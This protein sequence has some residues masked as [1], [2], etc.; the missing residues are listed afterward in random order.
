MTPSSQS[1]LEFWSRRL[2]GWSLLLIP[3]WMKL[4][5]VW[6]HSHKSLQR[7][8]VMVR[9]TREEFVTVSWSYR[10]FRLLEK[11]H[12]KWASGAASHVVQLLLVK[13]EQT[14]RKAA[15]CQHGVWWDVSVQPSA[16]CHTLQP[17]LPAQRR[18]WLLTY[19]EGLAH[20]HAP[21]SLI[22]TF[23][24]ACFRSISYGIEPEGKSSFSESVLPSSVIVYIAHRLTSEPQLT[25]ELS[26][27]T[28]PSWMFN[29]KI[30]EILVKLPNPLMLMTSEIFDHLK[31]VYTDR[32][33]TSATVFLLDR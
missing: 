18:I 9:E 22:N 33:E 20:K 27:C 21:A 15:S 2:S 5:P 24:F 12:W 23:C 4:V 32:R 16:A 19:A 11:L 17:W 13:M 29:S 7:Q 28:S 3:L 1:S 26:S 25:V 30:E 10:D 31:A 14:W 6:M 8:A